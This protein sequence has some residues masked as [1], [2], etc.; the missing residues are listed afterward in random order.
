M[1]YDFH[2]TRAKL[3]ADNEG[4]EIT[5]EEWLAVV[6]DDPELT[7]GGEPNYHTWRYGPG[8]QSILTRG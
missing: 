3:W 7:L 5:P 1:G 4:D 6:R 8:R 2:I